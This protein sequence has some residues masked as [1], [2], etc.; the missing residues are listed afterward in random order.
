MKTKN[1]VRASILLALGTVL[2]L[3]IP[4]LVN[5]MKPDFLLVTMFIA[6]LG[7]K[8]FK[9]TAIISLTA[10]I[11]AA[12]TTNFPGGQ[13]P[14]IIDKIVS[15]FTFLLLDKY[16]FNKFSNYNLSIILNTLINTLISGIIFL[17]SVVI[18][19]GIDLPGGIILLIGTV[20]IPTSILNSI[21]SIFLNK[22]FT[23]YKKS[24]A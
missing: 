4:G 8:D 14:S 13:L 12:M 22:V 15:G 6:I 7:N 1:L 24:I 9:S 17:I 19:T 10:G 18:I 5:G 3:I 20:V 2:H 23:V 11:L 16:I 21:F